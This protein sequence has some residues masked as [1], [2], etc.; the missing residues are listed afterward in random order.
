MKSQPS[1]FSIVTN[2]RGDWPCA[3]IFIRHTHGT[4]TIGG[5]KVQY[6]NNHQKALLWL[7]SGESFAHGRPF[8]FRLNEPGDGV[9]DGAKIGIEGGGDAAQTCRALGIAS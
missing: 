4:S 8:D 6:L 7:I 1:L 3:E 9:V 2:L 5:S